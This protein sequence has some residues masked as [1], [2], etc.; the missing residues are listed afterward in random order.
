MRIVGSVYLQEDC[1]PE[2]FIGMLGQS[3]VDLAAF[4]AAED[5]G[6]EPVGRRLPRSD[7]SN[8]LAGRV[9][10]G[11]ARVGGV[12]HGVSL[13]CILVGCSPAIGM[14]VCTTRVHVGDIVSASVVHGVNIA[15][16]LMRQRCAPSPL[17]EDWAGCRVVGVACHD[18]LKVNNVFLCPLG[19]ERGAAH[20]WEGNGM[21][22]AAIAAFEQAC[23]VCGQA[24]GT[25]ASI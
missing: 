15:I 4:L 8:S 20:H 9:H 2:T 19:V 1:C 21:L 17:T 11:H 24:A 13:P 23:E 22:V 6:S 5:S 14:T 16:S 12:A 3:N 18:V 7:A 25:T 10:V